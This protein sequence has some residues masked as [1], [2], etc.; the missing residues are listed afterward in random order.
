M[1]EA[2]DDTQQSSP[3]EAFIKRINLN[4]WLLIIA[5]VISVGVTIIASVSIYLLYS[6]VPDFEQASNSEA[7]LLKRIE[8]LEQTATRLAAFKGDELTKLQEVSEKTSSVASQC[9]GGFSG[10]ML[11]VMI[12]REQDFQVLVDSVATSATELAS[13][14]RG[15]REWLVAHDAALRA[16][17]EKSVKR[18]VELQYLGDAP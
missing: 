1:A 10:D 16:L 18:E 13:M 15:T 4:R 3:E 7:A 12:Q 11:E 5:L 9:S 8:E 6:N 2:D 14:T 17:R